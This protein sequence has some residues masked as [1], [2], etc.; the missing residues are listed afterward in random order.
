[1]EDTPEAGQ[2]N[3]VINTLR[4]PEA[5]S[6]FTV[7]I[8]EG[9]HQ[10][11]GEVLHQES[12][13]KIIEQFKER[14]G[15]IFPVGSLLRGTARVGSD[16]DFILVFDSSLAERSA[17][18]P[19]HREFEEITLTS[20]EFHPSH[21]PFRYWFARRFK[22][23]PK[24]V[25]FYDETRGFM[26]AYRE[27]MNRYRSEQGLPLTSFEEK[28]IERRFIVS[29]ALVFNTENLVQNIQGLS[30]IQPTELS[31]DLGI[32]IPQLLTTNLD[33]VVEGGP[34]ALLHHQRRIIEAL[35]FLEQ[36]NPDVFQEVY[37]HLSDN[38]H[39]AVNYQS[40]NHPHS[41]LID[42]QFKEYV[43]KSGRF[44]SEKVEHAA[45]LL[46]GI[47]RQNAFPSL[48]ALKEKYLV[49]IE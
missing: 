46:K 41:G 18:N 26:Q 11:F 17:G 42:T 22:A 48:Q 44:P 37:A 36:H 19:I 25:K 16:F 6:E 4:K 10:Y 3:K 27:R 24:L 8:L 29:E 9:F 23:D 30:I 34:G 40:D 43:E 35:V 38:F 49:G 12:P 31:S 28:D 39:A 1:M 14:K 15:M 47:K 7:G 13:P 33:Y 2:V 20:E 21:I 32:L 5:R 45:K